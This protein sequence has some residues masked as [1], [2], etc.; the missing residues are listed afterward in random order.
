[1]FSG[2]SDSQVGEPHYADD[3]DL[4]ESISEELYNRFPG[5]V[6]DMRLFK[7]SW[8]HETQG[9]NVFR[10]QGEDCIPH[11]N[12]VFHVNICAYVL[13]LYTDVCS[14]V[15]TSVPSWCTIIFM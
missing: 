2:R 7:H 13:H 8:S 6:D 4:Q 10:L 5:E 1:M 12:V 14:Y 3:N 15:C 9:K 11:K